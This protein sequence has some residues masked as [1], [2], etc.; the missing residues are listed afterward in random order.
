MEKLDFKKIER[1]FYQPKKIA[2]IDVPEMR[3]LTIDGEGA[4]SSEGFSEAIGKLFATA[5]T[6]SMSYKSDDAIP[7]FQPFVVPPLEGLWT[8]RTESDENGMFKKSDFIWKLMLRMPGFVTAEVVDWAR[9]KAEAKKK[10]NMTE[11]KFESWTDGLC[12]QAMHIGSFDDEP[13]TFSK[14]N[15]F[16]EE[17]GYQ[18]SFCGDFHHREIYLNDFNKTAPEKLKTV[19]RQYVKKI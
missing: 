4:P 2:L 17:K 1:E 14:I 18:E 15:A 16:A 11:L 3:F 19:I 10:L 12:V 9:A 5:Y 13:A 8:S 7:G 6:I